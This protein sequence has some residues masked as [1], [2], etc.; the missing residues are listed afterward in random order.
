M[1]NL[2]KQAV[3]FFGLSGIGWLIDFFLF[4]LLGHFSENLVLNNIIS[5]WVGVTFVFI[6][7][8]KKVF[9]NS[10]RLPLKVKY[11]IYLLYQCILIYLVSKLLAVFNG[12]YLEYIPFPALL[13]YSHIVSK[14]FITPV[15][16][17]C[18]FFV[19]KGLIE[20]I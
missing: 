19:M 6:L 4:A 18:N 8:P 7:A 1:V 20:K 11:V 10:K 16:M 9:K 5:S 12:L 2:L 15:T 13:P 14:I 3:R 17:I